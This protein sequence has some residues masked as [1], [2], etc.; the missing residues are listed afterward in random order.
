MTTCLLTGVGIL[1]LEGTNRWHVAGGLRDRWERASLFL[2]K[3]ES[4]REIGPFFWEGKEAAKQRGWA[5]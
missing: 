4:L 1:F 5:R 3:L 2:E